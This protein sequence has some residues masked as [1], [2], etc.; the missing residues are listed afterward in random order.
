ME[1]ALV[2]QLCKSL[3]TSAITTRYSDAVIGLLFIVLVQLLVVPTQLALHLHSINLPASILVMLVVVISM[4]IASYV[5]DEVEKLYNKYLRGP[6]DF[7]GRHMSLGFVAYFIL[8]IRDHI[9][10]ASEVPKLA[11][12]FGE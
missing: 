8:L 11:G 3:Q 2:Q 9:N 7:L 10:T 4:V 1:I 5:T 6:T 12:G